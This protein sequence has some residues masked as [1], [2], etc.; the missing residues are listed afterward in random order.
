M[1]LLLWGTKRLDDILYEWFAKRFCSNCRVY[2]S[3]SNG[4]D[5]DHNDDDDVNF[6]VTGCVFSSLRMELIKGTVK[7]KKTTQTV[8]NYIRQESRTQ[9]EYA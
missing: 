7:I 5:S 8:Q 3:I 6:K 2:R 1:E 4:F 9:A